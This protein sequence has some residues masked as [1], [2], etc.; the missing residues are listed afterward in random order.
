MKR[1]VKNVI[2]ATEK[3]ETINLYAESERIMELLGLKFT[4]RDVTTLT[5]REWKTVCK[6]KD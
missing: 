1:L 5:K 2:E 6:V 3:I 4:E